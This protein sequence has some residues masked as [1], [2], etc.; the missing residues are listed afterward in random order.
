MRVGEVVKVIP[1]KKIGFIR[2]E[3]LRQ[4]VFFHYSVVDSQGR[5]DLIE[6]DEVEYEIDEFARLERK[7]MRA[8]LVRISARPLTMRL[9]ASDAPELH[10]QHHPKARQKR[11]VWRKRA[12]P[13]TSSEGNDQPEDNPS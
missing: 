4:D 1:Q 12:E 5:R 10:S 8:T 13:D 3:G 6:G 7:E 11:P 2:T 9:K